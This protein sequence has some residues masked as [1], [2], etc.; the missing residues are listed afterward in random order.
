[1]YI[2]MVLDVCHASFAF[3]MK[4]ATM[5]LSALTL[6]QFAGENVSKFSN[7]AQRLIQIMKGGYALPYWLIAKIN[8][9]SYR[10]RLV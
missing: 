4:D 7:E 2:M 1:M 3:K 6:E 8:I 5:S 10:I 9:Y